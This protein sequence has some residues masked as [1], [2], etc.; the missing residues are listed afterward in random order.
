MHVVSVTSTFFR[1]T[2]N[3]Y[4]CK[5]LREAT[6]QD[7]IGRDC[8]LNVEAEKTHTIECWTLAL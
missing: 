5:L 1:L 4:L 6:T 2:S 7:D 8:K 3:H